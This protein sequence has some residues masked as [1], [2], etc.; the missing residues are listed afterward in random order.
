MSLSDVNTIAAVQIDV[1]P[2]G[3]STVSRQY[4]A[5]RVQVQKKLKDQDTWMTSDGTWHTNTR[6]RHLVFTMS[7]SDID[8]V[9]NTGDK[10][11]PIL[12]AEDLLDE[13]GYTVELYP[14]SGQSKK[15]TV[16]AWEPGGENLASFE[17]GGRTDEDLIRCITKEKVTRTDIEWFKK[18]S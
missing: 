4:V 7:G 2:D 5:A 18:T 10:R 13:S 17:H 12:L 14:D 15:F 3:G 8:Q 11:D 9:S 1:T 16:I 6:F